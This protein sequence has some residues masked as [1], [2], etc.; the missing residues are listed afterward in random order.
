MFRGRIISTVAPSLK[1]LLGL[2]GGKA[3]GGGMLDGFVDSLLQSFENF[4]AGLSDEALKA[5]DTA[6]QAFFLEQYEKELPRLRDTIRLL[7]I[8]AS[9]ETRQEAFR[10]IDELI[11][12]VVVPAYARLATRFTR[13]E[14]NDFYLVPE[15]LHGLERFAWGAVGM[16]LGAFV[17]WAPFIPLWD[18]EWVLPFAIAG[19]FLPNLRRYLALRRYQSELNGLAA[20]ADDEI[21]RMDLAYMT[22]VGFSAGTPHAA[23]RG[24]RLALPSA[25]TS[26]PREKVRP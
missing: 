22:G 6:A 9:D 11:R 3:R 18:K 2:F 15:P 8:G 14:R 20:G 7:E 25:G 10:R 1:T 5:G 19:L 12:R 23:E 4:R 17:I 16:G 13:R 21:W 24:E 26:V